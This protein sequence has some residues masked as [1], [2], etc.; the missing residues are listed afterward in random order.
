LFFSYAESGAELFFLRA[1]GCAID[2][3]TW[4]VRRNNTALNSFLDSH[5]LDPSDLEEDLTGIIHKEHDGPEPTAP[6]TPDPAPALPIT[7]VNGMF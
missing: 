5:R 3:P 7:L 1:G 6:A 2:F 4:R